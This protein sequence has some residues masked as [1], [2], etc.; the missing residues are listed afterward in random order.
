MFRLGGEELKKALIQQ[1]EFIMSRDYLASDF[2][3]VSQMN[4]EFFVPISVVME[5]SFIK[6]LTQDRDVLLAAMKSTDKVIVD[7]TRMMVKPNIKIQRNTIILRDIPPNIA[8]DV[9]PCSKEKNHTHTHYHTQ[10]FNSNI[11]HI[12]NI[13][14]KFTSKLLRHC[15]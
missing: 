8:T 6:A 14:Q 10:A 7:E 9:I 11:K 5:N 12:L 1:I 2:A 4:S 3:I 13:I 15:I